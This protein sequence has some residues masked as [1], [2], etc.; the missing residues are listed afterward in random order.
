MSYDTNSQTILK[1][2][3]KSYSTSSLSRKSKLLID[4]S[5]KR[6]TPTPSSIKPITKSSFTA[7]STENLKK[8]SSKSPK[9]QNFIK[10]FAIRKNIICRV[11][12]EREKNLRVEQDRKELHE[13][14]EKLREKQEERA[15]RTRKLVNY[16]KEFKNQFSAK[17]FEFK[18]EGGSKIKKKGELKARCVL[19]QSEIDS[20]IV[21][22]THHKHFTLQDLQAILNFRKDLPFKFYFALII[23]AFMN[24]SNISIS[25]DFWVKEIPQQNF[26]QFICLIYKK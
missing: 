23:S 24:I 7:R 10:D 25:S 2:I 3:G 20:E 26:F 9:S 16:E 22:E 12:N 4:S 19:R 18:F 1:A 6:K 11:L 17:N 15:K 13:K 14:Y 8:N 5:P 21:P